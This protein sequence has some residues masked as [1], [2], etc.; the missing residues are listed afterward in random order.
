MLEFGIFGL[1]NLLMD[2]SCIAPLTPVVIVTR[3]FIFQPLFCILLINGSYLACLCVYKIQYLVYSSSYSYNWLINQVV[4]Q[5]NF[6]RRSRTSDVKLN[7]LAWF[8]GVVILCSY[9]SRKHMHAWFIGRI[10]LYSCINHASS[11]ICWH[12]RRYQYS[13]LYC[14]V[15]SIAG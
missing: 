12:S 5:G 6:L 2:C 15:P 7:T 11:N 9:M 13:W 8:E 10:I 14:S 3:G 4:H 1:V